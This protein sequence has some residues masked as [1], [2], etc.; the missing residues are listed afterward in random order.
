MFFLGNRKG[1]NYPLLAFTLGYRQV[2]LS[3]TSTNSPHLIGVNFLLLVLKDEYLAVFKVKRTRAKS[4]KIH[5]S[6]FGQ[7]RFSCLS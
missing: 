4:S 5:I 1:A 6:S 7:R 2:T 3:L